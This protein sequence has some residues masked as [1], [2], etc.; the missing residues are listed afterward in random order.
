MF[1]GLI[2]AKLRCLGLKVEL[3]SELHEKQIKGPSMASRLLSLRRAPRF[4]KI[5]QAL[6]TIIPVDVSGS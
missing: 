1:L 2:Q 6:Q 5:C 4:A 3:F